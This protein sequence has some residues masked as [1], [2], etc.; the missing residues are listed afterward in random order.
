MDESALLLVGIEVSVAFAGFA[1]IIA[2]FQ[3][4]DEAKV[5]RAHVVGLTMIVNFSLMGAFFCALP[6]L[7]SVL[8]VEETTIWATS[9]G[10]QCVYTLNRMHYI[11]QNM[12]VV[13]LRSSSRLLFRIL[14][15]GASLIAIALALNAA[16][17]VFHREPGPSIAAIFFGL[18]LVGFM[19]ARLLLRPLW[20]VVREREGAS[21]G[22]TET[23]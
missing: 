8:R 9:S 13:A 15:G 12:S 19:F 3:N 20:R 7:L 21:S 14:Q 4:R 2:T 10:L 17:Q 22:P 1:G 23:R 6:L 18:G 5:D 16:N 11:H